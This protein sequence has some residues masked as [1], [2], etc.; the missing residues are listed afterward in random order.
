MNELTQLCKLQEDIVGR[1]TE[2]RNRE[3]A[4]SIAEK[5][6]TAQAAEKQYQKEVKTLEA[7]G[8]NVANLEALDREQCTDA[9]EELTVVRSQMEAM[10]QAPDPAASQLDLEGR[11]AC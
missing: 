2:E 1:I 7:M 8:L 6:A 11:D 9:E 4:E 10:S 3:M 5:R